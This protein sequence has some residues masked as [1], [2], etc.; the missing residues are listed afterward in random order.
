VG[1]KASDL[2]TQVLRDVIGIIGRFVPPLKAQLIVERTCNDMGLSENDFSEDNIPK[3]ILYLANKRDEVTSV[4]DNQFFSILK[5][6]VC[7]SNSKKEFVFNQKMRG[8][9]QKDGGLS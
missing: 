8:N 2:T 1:R 4:N 9:G 5:S 6:L 7:Y 3:F